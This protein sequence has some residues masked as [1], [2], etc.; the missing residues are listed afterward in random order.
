MFFV[1][2]NVSI[3]V[4]KQTHKLE[5]WSDIWFL[6]NFQMPA[7]AWGC[8][9]MTTPHSPY[10]SFHQVSILMKRFRSCSWRYAFLYVPPLDSYFSELMQNTSGFHHAGAVDNNSY[11]IPHNSF[12]LH[13]VINTPPFLA[14]CSKTL[15]LIPILL[16]QMWWPSHSFLGFGFEFWCSFKLWRTSPYLKTNC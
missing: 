4:N 6:L 1:K 16:Q 7:D 5:F 15:M 3:I 12:D 9:V 8:P 11:G 14:H 13:P 10:P 2:T